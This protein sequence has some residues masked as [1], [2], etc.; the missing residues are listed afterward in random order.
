VAD[1]LTGLLFLIDFFI[2]D[3]ADKPGYGLKVSWVNV[4]AMK[5]ANLHY[6]VEMIS[7]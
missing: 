7:S 1:K 5:P 2:G 3:E 6:H 4:V